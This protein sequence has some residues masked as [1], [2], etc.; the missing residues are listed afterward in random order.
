MPDIA[1]IAR[2]RSRKAKLNLLTRLPPGMDRQIPSRC[3]PF[4]RE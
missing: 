2:I 3:I 1:D 4:M